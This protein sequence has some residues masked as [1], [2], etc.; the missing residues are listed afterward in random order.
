MQAKLLS[1]LGNTVQCGAL[2]WLHF[3][4][5]S[6]TVWQMNLACEECSPA[7]SAIRQFSTA[8]HEDSL[9]CLPAKKYNCL[10]PLWLC[11][12]C[13][14]PL[15]SFFFLISRDLHIS[16]IHLFSRSFPSRHFFLQ[17]LHL[18]PKFRKMQPSHLPLA[19][20]HYLGYIS[21]NYRA[22]LDQ[23]YPSLRFTSRNTLYTCQ[24][25]QN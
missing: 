14:C 20:F 7:A 18:L 10:F 3:L 17:L 19:D 2:G 21:T 16:G 12:F 8:C 4:W 24:N 6:G 22:E 5:N 9:W 13:L 15:M 11:S 25:R 1:T 23:K